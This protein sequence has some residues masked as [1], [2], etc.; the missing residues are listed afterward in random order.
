MS[1]EENKEL[2]HRH[3]D[4]YWNKGRLE[5]AGELHAPDMVFHDP[6][7]P[8]LRG[9]AAYDQ[10]VTAYR[11]A[12]PD[13]QFTSEGLIA[14]GDMI[15]G[16]WTAMGTHEGE[17]MGIPPTGKVIKTTGIDIFRLEGGKIVEEWV[18]WSTLSMMQQLG[19][20]P[21]MG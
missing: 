6:T 7:Q 13:L 12:F 10:F 14:E 16:R 15:A 19:V 8:P 18:E 20:I 5:L 17:L 9:S 21:P 11:T 3:I 4:E 2:V 1:V